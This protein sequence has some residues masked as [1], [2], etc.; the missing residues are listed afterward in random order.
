MLVNLSFGDLHG[1]ALTKSALGTFLIFCQSD[2][3]CPVFPHMALLFD[4][5]VAPAFLWHLHARSSIL[6]GD[7]AT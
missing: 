4:S 2:A 1:P 5:T 7:M 3:K 6:G